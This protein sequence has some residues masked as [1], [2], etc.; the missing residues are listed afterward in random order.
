MACQA[1]QYCIW[2]HICSIL[3]YLWSKIYVY[4]LKIYLLCKKEYGLYKYFFVNKIC[5]VLKIIMDKSIF[6]V[7]KIFIV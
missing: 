1:L 3:K 7:Y 5:V 2:K 6:I 4:G